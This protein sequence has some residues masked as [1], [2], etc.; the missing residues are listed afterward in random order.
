MTPQDD[1]TS[2]GRILIALGVCTEGQIVRAKEAFPDELLGVALV[3]AGYATQQEVNRAV[4]Y[5]Q[6]LRQGQ[7]SAP[8]RTAMLM[9]RESCTRFSGPVALLLNGTACSTFGE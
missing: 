9:V 3:R 7:G 1:V 5:Q 6:D 8:A 4:A 2:L